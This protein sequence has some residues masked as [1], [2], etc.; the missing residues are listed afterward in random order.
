MDTAMTEDLANKQILINNL[1]EENRLLK[2]EASRSRPEVANKETE[3]K[4]Q[5]ALPNPPL[6]PSVAS[7]LQDIHNSMEQRFS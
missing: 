2:D 4:L 5:R 6:K 1:E 3:M 7:V